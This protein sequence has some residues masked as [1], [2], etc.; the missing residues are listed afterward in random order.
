MTAIDDLEEQIG[1]AVVVGQVTDLVETH[2]VVTGV[3]GEPAATGL[4]GGGGQVGD[5]LG[6]GEK[7]D[8]V[9]AMRGRSIFLGQTQSKSAMGL[10]A[11]R[12]AR[13][14]RRSRLLRARS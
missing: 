2:E 8:A 7:Q 4:R 13:L 10:K 1:G 12:R 3:E 9:T 6:G 5:Q 14:R 11:P